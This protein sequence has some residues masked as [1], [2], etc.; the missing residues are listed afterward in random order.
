[1]DDCK[2]AGGVWLEGITHD[3]IGRRSYLATRAPVACY[4]TTLS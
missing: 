2:T 4:P 1:M 3:E